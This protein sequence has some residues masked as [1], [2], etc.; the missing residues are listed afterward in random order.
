MDFRICKFVA[1]N[2]IGFFVLSRDFIISKIKN[3]SGLSRQN[4]SLYLSIG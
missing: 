3:H 2:S 4:V 1:E